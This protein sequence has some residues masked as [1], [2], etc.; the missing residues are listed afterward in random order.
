MFLLM[1]RYENEFI[2]L[3]FMYMIAGLC[4]S[5]IAHIRLPSLKVAVVLLVSLLVYDVFWVFCSSL[6]FHSNVMVAV[7]TTPA[8]NPVSSLLVKLAVTFST[9]E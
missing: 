6:L 9:N 8:D 4:V 3:F 7:A 5:L 1:Y 2:L